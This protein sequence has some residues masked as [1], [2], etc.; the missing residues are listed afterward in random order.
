MIDNVNIIGLFPIPVGKVELGREF[1]KKELKLLNFSD[2]EM[3]PNEGNRSSKNNYILHLPELKKLKNDLE[4]KVNEYFQF[5]WR[6]KTECSLYITQSWLNYTM[7]GQYHHRHEH[8]NSFISV[9]LYVDADV[10]NDKIQF[11]SSKGYQQLM[12]ETEE[13]N[14]YN[15]SS[16]WLSVKTYDI[17][18][19]PSSLTHMVVPK[20]GP[21]VRTSLAFN[22]FLKGTWGNCDSLTEM[23][24]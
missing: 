19:F 6:P 9:V 4:T 14:H 5:V 17:L 20:D 16:W 21:N 13:F 10:E 22:T 15:S 8:P 3:R 12:V 23:K 18:M 7:Q 24:L 11:I 1:S 2:D